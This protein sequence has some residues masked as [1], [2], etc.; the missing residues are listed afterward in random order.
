MNRSSS[1]ILLTIIA[2]VLLGAASQSTGG[3]LAPQL[4]AA[5]SCVETAED[6]YDPAAAERVAACVRS[7][8][9]KL[10]SAVRHEPTAKLNRKTASVARRRQVHSI[11]ISVR[12]R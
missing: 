6:G 1:A 11:P 4:H 2:C 8:A 7:L 9:L 10:Q 12:F 5:A 3:F